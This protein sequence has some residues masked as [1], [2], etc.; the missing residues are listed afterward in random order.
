MFICK[1][2][3]T[4]EHFIQMKKIKLKIEMLMSLY[5]YKPEIYQPPLKY[6]KKEEEILVKEDKENTRI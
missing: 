5:L 2:I 4:K 6:Y 3:I 1:N